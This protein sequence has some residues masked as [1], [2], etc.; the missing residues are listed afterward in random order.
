M[1]T[2][3]GGKDRDGRTVGAYARVPG[4]GCSREPQTPIR[5]PQELFAAELAIA[6]RRF[7]DH[8]LVVARGG[9]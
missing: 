4:G 9:R 1:E 7:D 8:L 3:R 5:T 2:R 6:Q